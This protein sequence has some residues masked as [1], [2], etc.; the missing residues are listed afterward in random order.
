MTMTRPYF[1][2]LCHLYFYDHLHYN[3]F[4]YSFNA[5][6]WA[7]KQKTNTLSNNQLIL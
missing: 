2:T 4:T 7:K 5:Y 6:H 3:I 1:S